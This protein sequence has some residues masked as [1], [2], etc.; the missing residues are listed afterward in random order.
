MRRRVWTA[1]ALLAFGYALLPALPAEAG[2][3]AIAYDRQSGKSGWVWNQPTAQ[4]AAEMALSQCGATGCKVIIHTAARQ[5]AAL[6]STENGKY[7][8]AAARKSQDEARLAALTDCQKGK[9]G[10]CVIRASDC[11]K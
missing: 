11:N 10:E 4:K 9:A 8:G 5:C 3:G 7:I 1:I 2:Y 6:A